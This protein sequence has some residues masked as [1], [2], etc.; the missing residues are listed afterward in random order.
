LDPDI[1]DVVGLWERV[2]VALEA[3]DVDVVVC[4][5]GGLRG[6]DAAT[7]DAL[8]RMQLLA[9]RHS[10]R[11]VLDNTSNRLQELLDLVGLAE[12][13]PGAEAEA[14]AR[15]PASAEAADRQGTMP[16]SSSDASSSAGSR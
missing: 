3:G 13:L 4:D 15:R 12:V 2:R 8:A 10:A 14:G 16:S 9:R 1:D 5:V 6:E 11:I 7:V